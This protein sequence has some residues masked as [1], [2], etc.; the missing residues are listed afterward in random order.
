MDFD[1]FHPLDE[2]QVLSIPRI[3]VKNAAAFLTAIWQIAD[4]NGALS[5]KPSDTEVNI[6]YEGTNVQLGEVITKP[7]SLTQEAESEVKKF[8]N[9]LAK[10]KWDLYGRWTMNWLKGQLKE[11]FNKHVRPSLTK[12]FNSLCM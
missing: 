4:D 2:V 12:E 5:I 8:L 10:N 1:I 9:N 7:S 11:S 3:N 6:K